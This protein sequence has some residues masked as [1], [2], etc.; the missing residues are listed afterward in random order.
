MEKSAQ[1]AREKMERDKQTAERVRGESSAACDDLRKKFV[2]TLTAA[3]VAAA[4]KR[5]QACTKMA[6][7]AQEMA[8]PAA[9]F[10]DYT[11]KVIPKLAKKIDDLDFEV[12]DIK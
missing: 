11:D 7:G 3:R 5:A 10:K 4:D 2:E 8:G 1:E 9:D 6:E 12:V